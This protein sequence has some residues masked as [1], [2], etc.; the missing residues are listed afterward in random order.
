[1]KPETSTHKRRNQ[2]LILIV[3]LSNVL[4]NLALSHGMRHSGAVVSASPLD[5][6][7]ALA[8]P[9]TVA[10]VVILIVWMVTDLALLSRADLSF[11]LPVTAGGYVLIA[12]AGHFWL[13]ER[14]SVLRWAG[15]AAITVG[16]VLAEETPSRTTEA[17]PE[18]IL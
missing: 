4:G 13:G 8:R 12:L 7:R 16:V 2:L 14:I 6:L 17:P 9:W 11:V 10:G 15:I 3:I 5:Y 1:M 18:Q